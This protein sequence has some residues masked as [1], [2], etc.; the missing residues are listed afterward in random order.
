MI[1]SSNRLGEAVSIH[2]LMFMKIT[3]K[4]LLACVVSLTAFSQGLLGAEDQPKLPEASKVVVYKSVEREG[5]KYDLKLHIFN[6]SKHDL[7]GKAPCI[8]MIHGGGWVSGE[9]SLFFKACERYA[10]RGMVAISVEYSIRSVHHGTPY[11]SVSDGKSAMRWVRKN[12]KDLGVY[13]DRIA[14]GGSSAGGHVAAA[15]AFL[16]GF[17]DPKDDLS[18]SPKPNALVLTSPVFDN[19]PGGYGHSRVKDRWKEFS[20]VHHVAKGAPPTLICMGDSEPTYLRV[21]VAKK[22]QADMK[23]LGSRCELLILEGMQHGKRSPEHTRQIQDKGDEFLIS[24][25]Y[26]KAK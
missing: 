4:S 17:D 9:P 5:K 1:R 14:A 21:E 2:T 19:G 16:S 12:A 6:P 20:P 26:M 10:S 24:L 25:G 23:Q 15:A 8:V 22:F 7:K 18:I 3:T 11:D 13:P